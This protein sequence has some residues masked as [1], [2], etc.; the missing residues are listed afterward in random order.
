VGAPR[1]ERAELAAAWQALLERWPWDWFVT[2]TFRGAPHPERAD[3]S[4]RLW[5]SR[6]NRALYG[7]RWAKKRLGI[8][9]CRATELQRRGA[10]HFHALVAFTESPRLRRLTWMDEWHA[11]AGFARIEPP[12]RSAAVAAYCAKYVTKDGEITLGGNLGGLEPLG[13]GS[14]LPARWTT[15]REEVSPPAMPPGKG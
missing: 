1:G 12:D 9:W 14:P 13:F 8:G 2:A 4:W 5:C 7:P 15:R 6:I 11:L 3:K 10:I